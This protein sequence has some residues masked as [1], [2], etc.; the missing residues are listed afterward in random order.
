MKTLAKNTHLIQPSVRVDRLCVRFILDAVQVLVEPI[1]QESHELL[2][3]VLGVTCKLTGFT[4]HNRLYGTNRRHRERRW[5]PW[6]YCLYYVWDMQVGKSESVGA[7]VPWVSRVG[8]RGVFLSKGPWAARQSQWPAC[9]L[10]PADY[11]SWFLPQML[12]LHGGKKKQRHEW[13][14]QTW[15][16]EA[17]I[18]DSWFISLQLI[19]PVQKQGG[20]DFGAIISMLKKMN[21]KLLNLVYADKTSGSY[22]ALITFAPLGHL[23]ALVSMLAVPTL[24]ACRCS[25]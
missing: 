20:L 7:C 15:T 11:C 8:R 1:Q 16:T 13:W 5:K 6:S 4:G 19:H 9:L 22:L 2:G 21:R 24:S 25:Q 10:F 12:D 23:A 14:K 17:R 3:I 18:E